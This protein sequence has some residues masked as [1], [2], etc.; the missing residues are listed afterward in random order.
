MPHETLD[1]NGR[2]PTQNIQ[3]RAREARYR[4]L[5]NWLRAHDVETLLTGHTLDDQ[6]ETFMLRLA[7]G[8]G[9]DGLSGMA[10]LA[11]FPLA[12]STI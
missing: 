8:S 5:G 9:L 7:R 1:W 6:A 10:P 12:N 3:A 4:L 2:K 11:P